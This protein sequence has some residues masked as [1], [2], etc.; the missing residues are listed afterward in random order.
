MKDRTFVEFTL[1]ALACISV[2]GLYALIGETERYRAE[3]RA[4]AARRWVLP[5]KRRPGRTPENDC[6]HCS[7]TGT[8]THCAPAD[9]RVCK[10]TGIQPR[11]AGLVGRLGTLWDG[12]A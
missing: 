12:A 1:G 10:G 5:R 8:C 2:L 7:G 9:C 3:Q 4:R 6:R 11:D